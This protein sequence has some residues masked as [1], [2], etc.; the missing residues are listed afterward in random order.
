MEAGI[1]AGHFIEHAEVLLLPVRTLPA[2]NQPS[3]CM[4]SRCRVLR[5]R[6]QGSGFRMQNCG[7]QVSGFRV[8]GSRPQGFGFRVTRADCSLA[9]NK[10]GGGQV[11]GNLYGTS[12]AAVDKVGQ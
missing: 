11:H 1:A 12:K 8:P 7:V 3:L 4:V 6:V 2:A 9:V 10:E 5:F